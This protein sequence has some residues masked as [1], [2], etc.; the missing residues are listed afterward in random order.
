MEDPDGQSVR[1]ADLRP[2]L[3]ALKSL[4]DGDSTVRVPGADEG[5]LGEMAGVVDEIV[6]RNVH[7]SSELRR[8]RRE[9]AREG[10][11]DERI[12]AS[13]GQGFWASNVEDANQLIEA[14]ATPVTRATRVLDAV[15]DGDLTRHMDLH[16]G[17]HRLKGGLQHL[18]DGLNRVVDQLALFTGEMTRV[19][20]EV[21]S[22][23]RLGGRAS[24]RAGAGAVRTGGRRRRDRLARRRRRPRP[25]RR[26]ALG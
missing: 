20:H 7:L 25:R 19:A 18:G 6:A 5:V 14:L 16:D 11:L 3:G 26:P 10:L 9:V 2:L 12:T 8:V 13:P 23:G 22:E 15:A 21:G 1:A 17:R 24:T 4:R